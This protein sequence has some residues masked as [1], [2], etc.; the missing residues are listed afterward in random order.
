MRAAGHSA[1][2][3]PRMETLRGKLRDRLTYANVVSTV[4]LFVVLGGTA[5]AVDGPLEGQNTVG[6][7]DI[8]NGEVTRSDLA[9][10]AVSNEQ[11]A[12]GRVMNGDLA[13]GATDSNTTRDNGLRSVDIRDD[14]SPGGGLT[15]DD[16]VESTLDVVPPNTVL[17]DPEQ[18]WNP[19]GTQVNFPISDPLFDVSKDAVVV[20]LDGDS[21]A[22]IAT[23][24]VSNL[25]FESFV[26]TCTSAPPNG[27]ELRY[28]VI[29]P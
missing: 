15:G 10:N 1:S 4:C 25:T 24:A 23:C 17:A 12:D 29:S 16:I 21:T 19:D 14:T 28:A 27:A 5:A 20:N 8:I 13:P 9:A 3:G 7:S 6:S 18:G 11:I 26:V 2:L 22:P